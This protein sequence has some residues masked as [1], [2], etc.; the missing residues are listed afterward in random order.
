M[1]LGHAI[2][3][4]NMSTKIDKFERDVLWSDPHATQATNRLVTVAK[5]ALDALAE[6]IRD[7]LDNA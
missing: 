6:Q 5:A 1:N 2:D 3:I 4:E 7:D